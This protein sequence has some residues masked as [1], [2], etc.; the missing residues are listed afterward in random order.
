MLIRRNFFVQIGWK[1]KS[2]H[3]CSDKMSLVCALIALR[4]ALKFYSTFTVS[5]A[6]LIPLAPPMF[7]QCYPGTER[8]RTSPNEGL[9]I[10][11]VLAAALPS[12]FVGARLAM[13][14]T[15]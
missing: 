13:A 8:K 1:G 14:L 11:F 3:H 7:H 2:R 12:I 10:G 15:S 5:V 4:S 6:F 9:S